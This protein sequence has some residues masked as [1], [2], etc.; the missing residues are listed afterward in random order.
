MMLAIQYDTTQCRVDTPFISLQE[1]AGGWA[2]L[3]TLQRPRSVPALPQ[4]C[5][6]VASGQA[7]SYSENFSPLQVALTV[8]RAKQVLATNVLLLVLPFTV[9]TFI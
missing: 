8:T 4:K 5:L 9:I 3:S 2:K 7:E 6:A 1:P